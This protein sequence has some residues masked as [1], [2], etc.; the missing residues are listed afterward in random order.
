MKQADHGESSYKGTGRL[1]NRRAL[2]TGADSG[3]G[4]AVA[5]AFSREGADIAIS[6]LSEE[7]D[8]RETERLVTD[9][10]RKAVLL[11]GD[12]GDPGV[13][14]T[15]S[16]KTLDAFGGI[17][18]LVNKAAFQRTY[19]KFEGI[20]DDEFEETYRVN[21]FAMFRLCD[22]ADDK[23]G[24]IHHQ[25]GVHSVFRPQPQSHRLRLEQSRYRQLHSFACQPC[26]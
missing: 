18:I 13:C 23:R 5:L 19:E 2:I 17:D 22:P 10:G 14:A 9:A 21:V 12:V 26:N 24:R 3:I 8:A 6:Y 1:Q 11:P 4:R 25:Y 7:A 20:P 15:V 16:R